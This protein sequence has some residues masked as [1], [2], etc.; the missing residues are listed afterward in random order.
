MTVGICCMDVKLYSRPMTAILNRLRRYDDITIVSFGNRCI[1]DRPV[2]LWPIVDFLICFYS[3]GFPL[4]KAQEYV[5]LREPLCFNNVD[6]QLFLLDRTVVYRMLQENGIPVPRYKVY[7]R[8]TPGAISPQ[9]SEENLPKASV[10]IP[11]I[12]PPVAPPVPLPPP[13][14]AS[15]ATLAPPTPSGNPPTSLLPT[16][17]APKPPVTLAS[18]PPSPLLSGKHTIPIIDPITASQTQGARR[19]SDN[20][21]SGQQAADFERYKKMLLELKIDDAMDEAVMMGSEP[22]AVDPE[23]ID[24][25]RKAM[26]WGSEDPIQENED[27]ICVHGEKFRKP[28]V[29]K[30]V[31]AEDHNIYVYYPKSSGGGSKRLFRKVRDRSSKF[32]PTISTVR[33][34]GSFIYEDFISTDGMDVKV[35]T[36]GPDYAHAEARKAPTV[37]GRV[38]RTEEGKEVRY[39]VILNQAEKEIARKIVQIFKQNIC[40]FDLLRTD[41]MSYVCDVNGFSFVKGSPKYYNDCAQIIYEMIQFHLHP[42]G[43]SRASRLVLDNDERLEN[44]QQTDNRRRE[45]R[46]VLAVIRHGDRTPKQKVKVKVSHPLILKYFDG[47]DPKK[48]VKFKSVKEMMEFSSVITQIVAEMSESDS[49]GADTAPPSPVAVMASPVQQLSRGTSGIL[50]R[51]TTVPKYSVNPQKAL[52][53]IKEALNETEHFSGINRKVQIKP[54]KW[55]FQDG[56]DTK[57]RVSQALLIFKYGGQLTDFGFKQADMLGNSFRQ[58]LYPRSARSYLS[59]HSSFAHDIKFYA[60]DEGRVQ[61]TAAMFAKAFLELDEDEIIPIRYALVGND[62]RAIS[63]LDCSISSSSTFINEKRRISDILNADVDFSESNGG[64]DPTLLFGGVTVEELRKIGVGKLG[65]PRKR[66]ELVRASIVRL[67]S[68]LKQVAT[69]PPSIPERSSSEHLEDDEEEDKRSKE[70]SGQKSKLAR[71][72]PPPKIDGL[73]YTAK[74]P[75]SASKIAVQYNSRAARAAKVWDKLLRM[76]YN[77]E[78]GRYDATK[79]SDIMDCAMFHMLHFLHHHFQPLT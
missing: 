72:P 43:L 29:E 25:Q 64:L 73:G 45:L 15:E 10:T 36:V 21:S 54:L 49:D 71:K 61:M 44:A 52:L 46:C 69:P 5:R 68:E 6:T 20:I 8:P 67:L 9:I 42:V 77:E 16:S 63:W 7:R 23:T 3:A 41:T 58:N 48:Q 12:I 30:P 62:D 24:A 47:K 26:F 1:F 37:D 76:F 19:V 38:M 39:H 79:V 35:Y 14:A 27:S 32:F 66:L 60:S 4:D 56:D 28:F 11:E 51:P 33:R 55:V 78:T 2:E 53:E 22:G 40:G 59:L 74:S 31:W 65:N 50:S 57:A 34:D 70:N 75:R 17:V 13:A 18:P